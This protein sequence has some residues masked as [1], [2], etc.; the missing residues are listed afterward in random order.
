MRNSINIT[1]AKP[2]F[3]DNKKFLVPQKSAFNKI[4]GDSNFELDFAEFL[5]ESIDIISFAKNYLSLNF[6]M[7]YQGEDGNLHDY[8]PDFF[9]KESENSIY[10]I[11]T[12]GREDLND[13]RKIARLKTWCEDVNN[14]QNKIKYIPL[15]VK[16][17]TWDKYREDIR[18]FT[19]IK[20]IFNI[21]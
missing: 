5:E 4:I 6:R 1:D 11:E 13:I 2:F 8:Y 15:Y 14:L 3:A 12:K 17:E 9:V 10:I 21:K 7:E 19:D 18:K 16:Q 20:K